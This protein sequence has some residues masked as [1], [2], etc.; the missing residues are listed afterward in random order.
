M[1]LLRAPTCILASILV[2]S[3]VLFAAEVGASDELRPGATIKIPFGLIEVPPSLYSVMSGMAIPPSLTVHL[4]D[5]YVPTHRYPLLVYVPGNDGGPGGNISNAQTI[6]GP[7]GWIVA[8]LPLFKT[9]VDRGEPG[10]GVIVSFEDYPTLSRAYRTMLGR[11]FD[12]VPNIDREN[13]AMVGFSNGAI[14]IGVLV[15]N[16]DEFILSHFKSF[17]LVDHGMFH[18]TDLHKSDA[19]D[20]RYLILVG[21]QEDLGR[22]LKLRQ[23]RLLQDVWQMVEVDLSYRVLKDTGHEFGE[24]QMAI[25]GEWLGDGLREK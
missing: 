9:T 4:P 17:C 1:R 25:V 5:D 24:P 2:A 8:S 7:K 16:H 15:S 20:G 23:G 11:L 10:G 13:S 19:K 18:L 22:E 3:S 14:T 6:A 12:R 21:D